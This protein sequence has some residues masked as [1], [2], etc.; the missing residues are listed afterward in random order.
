[1]PSEAQRYGGRAA[2]VGELLEGF[3]RRRRA[4]H[5][6]RGASRSQRDRRRAMLTGTLILAQGGRVHM[7][8]TRGSNESFPTLVADGPATREN[9]LREGDNAVRNSCWCRTTLHVARAGE[10]A[11]PDPRD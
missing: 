1:M 6:Q 5:R 3:L 8:R 2:Q 11:R 7:L 4:G 9:T 10:H